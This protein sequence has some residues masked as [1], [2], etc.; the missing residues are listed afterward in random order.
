V[1]EHAI[2]ASYTDL[3]RQHHCRVVS[4]CRLM[5]SDPE[6]AEEVAQEVFMTL[7]RCIREQREP[8]VWSYWLTR[9]AVNA[10]RNH[11]RSRWRTWWRTSR[12]EYV[13]ERVPGGTPSPEDDVISREGQARIWRA[14]RRL[15]VRQREVLVMRQL[16]G[17]STEEVADALGVSAG[18]VKQHLF[19]AVHR[20]RHALEAGT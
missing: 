6:D 11:R 8:V 19:R 16:E 10:C 17:W 4:I 18:T 7:L 5:L 20:L 13:E 15:P 2:R 9:V 1:G 3:Y 14:V 12:S